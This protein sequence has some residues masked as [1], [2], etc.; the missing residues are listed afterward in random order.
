MALDAKIKAIGFDM[1]GTF[2]DTRVDYVKL[3]NVVTDAYSKYGV[4]AD[5]LKADG[6]KLTMENCDRWIEENGLQ[7]HKPAIDNEIQENATE[8][9][10]ENAN[11][12]RIFPGAVELL[13][14]MK[15]KGLK[16]GI[17]TRGGRRYAEYVLGN[18]G[19]L[20]RFD[21]L[22][23]R[24]DYPENEAKPSPLA[25]EHLAKEFGVKCDE[26]LYVGDGLVDYLTA[27]NSGARFI[28]VMSGHDNRT[29]DIWEAKVGKGV[30]IVRTIADLIPML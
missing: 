8:I 18:A 29:R 12:A 13:D 20:D 22:V 3:A 2:M 10:M 6:Y 7:K 1:D 16:A 26:I 11:V 30:E 27:Y 14:A 17:L 28:G 9:E 21:A 24:D 23:A 25:M 15:A 5:V 19:V 4:P